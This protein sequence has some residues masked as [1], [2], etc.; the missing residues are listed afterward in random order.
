VKRGTTFLYEL[1]E[2]AS[3]RFKIDRKLLGRTV[4]GKCKPLTAKNRPRKHCVSFIKASPPVMATGKAGAN[5][6]P[7]SGRRRGGKVL[8]PGRYRATAVATDSAGGRSSPRF[9][10]FSVIAGQP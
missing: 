1:S 7:Y 10:G 9:V 5:K 6:T 8:P 2:A 4:G 3:V